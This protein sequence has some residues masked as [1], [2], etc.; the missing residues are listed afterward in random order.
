MLMYLQTEPFSLDCCDAYAEAYI[1]GNEADAEM[2]IHTSVA[3]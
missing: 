3:C 2:L 1:Y